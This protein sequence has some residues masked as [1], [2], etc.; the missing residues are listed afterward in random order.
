VRI[1]SFAVERSSGVG[2]TL[3]GFLILKARIWPNVQKLPPVKNCLLLHFTCHRKSSTIIFVISG[4]RSRTCYALN[5]ILFEIY[6]PVSDVPDICKGAVHKWRH[7]ILGKNLP[8][9]PLSH[10]VKSIQTPLQIQRHNLQ[11]P[12]F[13]LQLQISI[14]FVSA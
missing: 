2:L 9:P 12:T 13:Y 14:Y 5:T 7:T 10:F 3:S 6:L 4:D 1:S 11:P 8:F